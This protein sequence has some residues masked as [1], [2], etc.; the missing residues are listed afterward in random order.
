MC[1]HT[2]EK[3]KCYILLTSQM[4]GLQVVRLPA[5]TVNKQCRQPMPATLTGLSPNAGLLSTTAEVQTGGDA[6]PASGKA[7]GISTG[8]LTART[9][10]RPKTCG[11][12]VEAASVCAGR[13]AIVRWS[14]DD[15][16]W[17]SL[18]WSLA[19]AE[20][21]WPFRGVPRPPRPARHTEGWHRVVD[22]RRY[23]WDIRSSRWWCEAIALREIS[24]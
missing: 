22:P 15:G 24:M 11:L 18:H 20:P 19:R 12:P 10:R 23:N 4:S 8:F 6:R 3:V 2:N 9:G 21:G 16:Q 17:T 5:A 13:R 7:T 14:G 1:R